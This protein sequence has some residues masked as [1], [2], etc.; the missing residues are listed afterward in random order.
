MFIHTSLL[1]PDS[2][3]S[4]RPFI[5]LVSVESRQL[6]FRWSPVALECP[7]VHYTINASNCGICPTTTNH[8][9]VTCT[10]VPSDGSICTF[11]LKTVVCGN[12][13]GKMSEPVSVQLLS[14][15]DNTEVNSRQADYIV[16][17]VSA[18][19]LA[20]IFAISTVFFAALAI[21]KGKRRPKTESEGNRQIANYEDVDSNP[22]SSTVAINTKK[23]VSYG[24]VH[25]NNASTS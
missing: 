15:N 17:I 6:K 21:V 22:V 18:G 25:I 5:S 11:A 1:S 19:L 14:N 2:L 9:N 7:E 20:G 24:Q 4:S 16:A 10:D 12:I 8:I 23:N 3:P 13:Y